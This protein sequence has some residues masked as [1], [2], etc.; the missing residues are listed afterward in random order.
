MYPE[1]PVSAAERQGPGQDLRAGRPALRAIL[2]EH[3]EPLA[4]LIVDARVAEWDRYLDHTEG[5]YRAMH[6][7]AALIAGLLP[8]QA[9]ALISQLTG[10]RDLV[11][12]DDMLR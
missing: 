6:S 7:T 2:R 11:L 9:A 8:G 1:A 10:G 5:R 4:A 12:V 3:R